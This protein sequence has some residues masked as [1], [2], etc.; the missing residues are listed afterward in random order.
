MTAFGPRPL[1]SRLAR[2]IGFL[3]LWVAV[4]RLPKLPGAIPERDIVVLAEAGVPALGRLVLAAGRADTILRRWQ[5]AGLS[6]LIV[7]TLVA[8]ALALGA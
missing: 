6:L 1:S 8:A 7:A 3:A 2:G 5:V 4:S